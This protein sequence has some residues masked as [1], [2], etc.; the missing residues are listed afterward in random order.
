MIGDIEIK[1]VILNDNTKNQL[2]SRFIA[3]DVET[4]GLNPSD[5][6]ITE[7]GLVLFENGKVTKNYNSLI[8]ISVSI[9]PEIVSLTGIT[10]EMLKNAKSEAEVF[11]EVVDF[12]GDAMDE[13]TILVAHNALFD[14]SFLANSLKRYGYIG[15][16][17]YVDTLNL[18]RLLVHGLFNYKQETVARYFNIVNDNAH[19]ALSDALTCGRI[20]N[21]LLDIFTSSNQMLDFTTK[22]DHL[23]LDNI[24]E[25]GLIYYRF[26]KINNYC[27]ND[28][29]CNCNII[30]ANNY[31]VTLEINDGDITGS[32]TCPYYLDNNDNCKHIYALLLKYLAN[33][34]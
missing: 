21:C 8:H 1:K 28:N 13:K 18:S 15:V 27:E 14:L 2:N 7:I 33:K 34:K 17:N 12:L 6:Y 26:N 32:C 3:I 9:P 31:N 29:Q 11:R 10:D 25:R 23:F 4:T 22:Y 20:L 24:R 19:R 16:I 30:G 5:D